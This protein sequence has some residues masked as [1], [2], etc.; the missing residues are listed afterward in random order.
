MACIT[1][2]EGERCI[3]GLVGKTG[4]K[5]NHLEDPGVDWRLILRWNFRKRDVRVWTASILLR[6]GAG[7][8]HL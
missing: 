7:G 8:G 5:N 1:Y 4:G 3:Q 6:I 2:G